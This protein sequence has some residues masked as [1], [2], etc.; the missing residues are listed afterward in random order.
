VTRTPVPPPGEDHD[1]PPLAVEI[2]AGAWQLLPLAPADHAQLRSTLAAEDPE[3]WIAQADGHDR[4]AVWTIR[5]A[6]GGRCAG[7]VLLS[8]DGEGGGR[9]RCRLEDPSDDDAA[10]IALAAITRYAAAAWGA[11]TVIPE[12]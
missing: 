3:A 7:W 2:A 11:T 10:A 6:V 4:S 8:L 12:P 5:A 9:I 1:Q